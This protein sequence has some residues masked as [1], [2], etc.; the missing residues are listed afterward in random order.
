[1]RVLHLSTNFFNAP[2]DGGQLRT[3]HLARL[4][5]NHH[6]VFFLGMHLPGNP[7]TEEALRMTRERIGE[8]SVIERPCSLAY[9]I[10]NAALSLTG[11]PPYTV[12]NYEFPKFAAALQRT[13]DQRG[14]DL[15]HA[16][17]P[18]TAQY[19]RLFRNKPSV[20]DAHNIYSQLWRGFA[21]QNRK[22]PLVR[23]FA[24]RQAA[25]VRALEAKTV[26]SF[27][28][29]TVCSDQDRVRA[30]EWVPGATVF[31]IPNGVDC[32]AFSP[33]GEA[34][35]EPFSLVYTAALNAPANIDA[36][37]Y[38]VE[39]IL[40]GILQRFPQAR[41][42]LV[43]RDP[44]AA[45]LRLARDNVNGALRR[46]SPEDTVN[47]AL[48]RSSSEG[49]VFICPNV[50]DVRPYQARAEVFVVP[51]RI[52]SGTRIK[53][54]EAMAMG[55][56][57]VSTTCG[58]EGIDYTDG[59]HLLIADTPEAF[60]SAVG[61][62]FENPGLRSDLGRNGRELAVRHYDWDSFEPLLGEVY[63]AAVQKHAQRAREF[64]HGALGRSSSEDTEHG[65][66]RSGAE[67]LRA[68]RSPS[69]DTK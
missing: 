8:A 12:R 37:V 24:L 69:E 60:V 36:S 16:H 3:W 56:A 4:A 15:V 35:R 48:G 44:A 17:H 54:L 21:D 49:T 22:R 53:I 50:P 29:T 42:Y 68:P 9:R 46:S 31:T 14:I 43:G 18:H 26:R 32:Q 61:R 7:P 64:E 51:L 5:A 40:P 33:H 52:G 19:W 66:L 11:G 59:R 25:S 63:E 58:A 28:V 62:L 57:V 27:D 23:L 10:K 67:A 30:L 38:F 1:M 47:G 2:M 34:D 41:L 45:V 13:L 65:A 55:A 6:E 20:Y 39:E